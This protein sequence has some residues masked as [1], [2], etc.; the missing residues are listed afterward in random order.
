MLNALNPQLRR[1]EME[2]SIIYLTLIRIRAFL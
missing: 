1:R 2:N